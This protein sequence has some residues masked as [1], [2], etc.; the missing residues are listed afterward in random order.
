[1]NL[2]LFVATTLIIKYA[3]AANIEALRI[4]L[5]YSDLT[6]SQ[7]PLSLDNYSQSVYSY[8][9]IQLGKFVNSRS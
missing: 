9:R 2:S 6:A 1:M 3:M 4:I 7:N 8:K 5:G